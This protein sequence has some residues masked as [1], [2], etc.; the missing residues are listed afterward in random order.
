MASAF[1]HAIAAVAIGKSFALKD[2][3][4]KFWLLGIFCSIIPDA[5]VIGFQFGVAYGSFWGHRGFSHSLLFAA[6]LAL[7]VMLLFYRHETIKTLRW[8]A[9]WLYL[10]LAT[11]SHALLDAMTT[12]GKGVAFFSPF[13]N[14]RYFLPW[15][16]IQV[17]PI[18]VEKFF[19][20]RGLRVLESELLWVFL[21]SLVLILVFHFAYKATGSK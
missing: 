15:R 13:D 5:D 17:S 4:W 20:N 10:F 11:A 19:S 12:G 16:P 6:L 21:P 1:A 14:A 7:L 2:L 18:G 9:L 3:G 8:W